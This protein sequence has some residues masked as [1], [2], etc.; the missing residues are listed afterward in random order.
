MGSGSGYAI[1]ARLPNCVA[2]REVVEG[3]GGGSL[4]G[5]RER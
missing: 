3:I 4:R 1:H 5:G 2:G